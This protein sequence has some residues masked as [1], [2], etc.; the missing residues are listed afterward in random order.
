M[1]GNVRDFVAVDFETANPQRVSACAFGYAIVKD[2]EIVQTNGFL[3]KP[4][5]GH[6]PFQ[7]KIH[8]L[9]ASDTSEKNDF[10]EVYSSVAHLFDMPIVGHSQFDKQVLNALSEHFNLGIRFSYVDSVS[11]AREMLPELKNHKLK[12]LVKHLDLPK[13]KHHDA[14]EDARACASVLIKLQWPREIRTPDIRDQYASLASEILADGEVDYAEAYQL[15]YWLED[16]AGESADLDRLLDLVTAALE[17]DV[18]D[19]MESEAIKVLL[20]LSLKKFSE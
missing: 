10:G 20:K 14:T 13:F 11:V 9:T 7:T 12:T 4:V 3:V 19:E 2:L 6:A 15:L 5:G 1:R 8:G 16:H 18:L 17:D